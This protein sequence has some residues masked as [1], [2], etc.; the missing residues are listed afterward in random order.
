MQATQPPRPWTR[1]LR[2]VSAGALILL[3]ACGDARRPLVG[4]SMGSN[5]SRA[6]RLA[7]ERLGPD[8]APADLLVRVEGS[9]F[10]E[11]AIA[12]ADTLVS[13]D[14][15]IAVV[16]HAN[17]GSSLAASQ[18]YNRARVVQLAP[19]S[20]A[21][22][23][24]DAG[25]FSFRMVS[26]DDRQ[27]VFLAESLAREYAEARL[28]VFYV[29]DD[30]GRGLRSAFTGALDRDRISVELELPHVEGPMD[31]ATVSRTMEAVERAG[32]DVIVWLG[33]SGPLQQYLDAIRARLGEIPIL[34]GDAAGQMNARTEWGE[35]W[36]GVQ[37]ADFAYPEDTPALRDFREAYRRRFGENPQAP[38][39]L[40]YDAVTLVMEGIRSGAR[41][42]PELRDFL[43]SLGRDRP[44][45]PGL[46]GPITFEPD[47]DVD[48]GYVLR[49]V[50]RPGA[51]P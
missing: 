12:S 35:A 19:H 27:G 36:A 45:F 51:P 5:A 26:S 13:M 48:R 14:E 50:R 41:T 31:T 46:S 42:G 1:P 7:Q 15:L 40:T 18:I 34:G 8:G 28:V 2:L 39:I 49:E 47:G 37:Y 21:A 29:N 3:A 17:S 23:Y 38:D 10:A 32:P 4:V 30:Y 9:N 6:A 20:T 25:P 11:A 24:S 22:V 43:M 16:G 44:P 33:R